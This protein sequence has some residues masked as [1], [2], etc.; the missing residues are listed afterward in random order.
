MGT[1]LLAVVFCEYESA[2]ASYR[3]ISQQGFQ[4]PYGN[5]SMRVTAYETDATKTLLELCPVPRE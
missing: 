2:L 5:V 3:A 1:P 4:S